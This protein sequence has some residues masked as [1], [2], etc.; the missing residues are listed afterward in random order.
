MPPADKDEV[1]RV[2]MEN[3]FLD[4][5]LTDGGMYPAPM[6]MSEAADNLIRFTESKEEPFSPSW[7]GVNPWFGAKAG[8]GGGC[9]IL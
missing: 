5:K 4:G 2:T 9:A 1:A 3:D 6:K 7:G 8:G